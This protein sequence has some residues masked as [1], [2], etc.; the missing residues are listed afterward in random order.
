MNSREVD[1]YK[2][3]FTKNEHQFTFHTYKYGHGWYI[4]FYNVYEPD[5]AFWNDYL[6]GLKYDLKM[7]KKQYYDDLK[8]H[9][10]Y[11][12]AQKEMKKKLKDEYN[13]YN[14]WLQQLNNPKLGKTVNQ[15]QRIRLES[16]VELL[17]ELLNGK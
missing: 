13:K 16:K 8:R 3:G 14:S 11:D 7:V 17:N 2:L 1:L 9:S 4:D 10:S 15:E 6:E 5:D 12:F